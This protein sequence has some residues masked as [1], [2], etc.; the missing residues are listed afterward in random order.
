M[1]N[2]ITSSRKENV[3]GIYICIFF[4]EAVNLET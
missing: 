4:F 3:H 1:K 2:G